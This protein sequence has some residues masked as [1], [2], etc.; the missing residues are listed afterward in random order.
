MARTD[1]INMG[2]LT[3]TIYYILLSLLEEKH[4]YLIMQNV[5]DMTN[6]KFTIGPGSLYTSL[7][8]LLKAELIEMTKE[9]KDNKKIY[10]IT[11]KGLRM[12]KNEVRR[13]KNMVC[14]AE[15]KL[16]EKGEKL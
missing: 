16:K 6:G 4:G 1:S 15:I 10:K 7:K 3:D 2:E 12:L 9:Q 8:K 13:K 11:D 5:N 14:Q